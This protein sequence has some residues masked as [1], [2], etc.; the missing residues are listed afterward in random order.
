MAELDTLLAEFYEYQIGLRAIL[1]TGKNMLA[2]R[3]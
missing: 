1:M 3:E 2:S